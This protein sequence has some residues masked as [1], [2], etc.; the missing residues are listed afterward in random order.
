MKVIITLVAFIALIGVWGVILS[1]KALKPHAPDACATFR[2][3]KSK[4]AAKLPSILL[5]SLFFLILL[6]VFLPDTLSNQSA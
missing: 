6:S 5:F 1:Q 3:E 2:N 4:T